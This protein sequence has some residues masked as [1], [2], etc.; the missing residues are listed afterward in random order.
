MGEHR[1]TRRTTRPILAAVPLFRRRRDDVVVEPEP[2]VPVGP[3]PRGEVAQ[4]LQSVAPDSGR[5]LADG[6]LPAI[7][8]AIRREPD[9]AID[10][11]RSKLGGA[12][13][14][15]RGTFWPS[16][17]RPDGEKQ[18]LQFFAQVDLAEAAAAAPSE[19]GLPADGLLSFFADF[20]PENGSV[21]RPEAVVFYSPAN[22]QFARCSLRMVPVATAQLHP[23]GTWSWPASSDGAGL[24]AFEQEHESGL[25][26]QAPEH[27]HVTARHQLGGHISGAD[28]FV[29]LQFDSDPTMEVA[30]GQAGGAG[31]LV[32]TMP[33][34]DMASR[35]WS[36]G[37]FSLLP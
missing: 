37:R 24:K 22:S 5:Q 6:L 28:G 2:V 1:G 13:D 11:A 8:F 14:L 20:D 33:A 18:L 31:R 3:A 29:L 15:P 19:L 4:R 27:Y 32:W 25:H 17:T 16:W 10:I 34:A 21:P 9:V 36:T 7:R 12:P 35:N 26:T 30:W 23:L